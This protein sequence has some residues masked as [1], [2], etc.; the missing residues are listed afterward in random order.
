M[1]KGFLVLEDGRV[2]SG[3]TNLAFNAFGKV[4]LN[5]S[6]VMVNSS[7]TS[8]NFTLDQAPVLETDA[9]VG[10]IVVDQLPIEYHMY[11]V[12]CTVY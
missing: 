3:H 6:D 4:T 12:K 9:L 5:G 7:S 8:H 11:D 2:L 1:N 10:K